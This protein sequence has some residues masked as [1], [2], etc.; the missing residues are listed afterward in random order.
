MPEKP[1]PCESVPC[2][3]EH[4]I[5]GPVDPKYPGMFVCVRCGVVFVVL[6]IDLETAKKL[7]AEV[8]SENV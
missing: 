5:V 2:A 4:R 3:R 6:G 1:C 7:L 8:E